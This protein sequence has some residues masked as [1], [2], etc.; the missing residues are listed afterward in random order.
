MK[1]APKAAI[2]AFN[3]SDDSEHPFCT[4]TN[5]PLSLAWW[6]DYVLRRKLSEADIEEEANEPPLSPS[7]RDDSTD[8]PNFD[9]EINIGEIRLM[10]DGD[11]FQHVL[12]YNIHDSG[13][14]EDYIVIPFSMYVFP[15]TTGE[16][17]LSHRPHPMTSVVQIWGIKSYCQTTMKRS[18][19][20]D[21]LPESEMLLIQ[22]AVCSLMFGDPISEEAKA[23]L[24]N[25]K[26]VPSQDDIQEYL[27]NEF[28]RWSRIDGIDF[29]RTMGK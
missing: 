24:G 28:A 1:Q 21:R 6:E 9:K 22:E 23:H 25:Q 15:A 13:S 18:A 17:I 8:S 5:K 2:K 3:L 26:D 4:K 10:Y 27:D 12:V 14:H 16:Y 7:P 11:E 29:D 19:V 20:I